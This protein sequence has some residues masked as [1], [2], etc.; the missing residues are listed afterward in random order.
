MSRKHP[1]FPTIKR[2]TVRINR[3][4]YL[5]LLASSVSFP[6]ADSTAQHKQL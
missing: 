4:I 3:V 5:I 2:L 6:L 1:I